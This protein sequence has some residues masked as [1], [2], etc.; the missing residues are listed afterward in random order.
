M[1]RLQV[2]RSFA[3]P[4]KVQSTA[5]RRTAHLENTNTPRA[6]FF[7]VRAA[8]RTICSYFNTSSKPLPVAL[9]CSVVEQ[10]DPAFK[11]SRCDLHQHRDG[12]CGTATSFT[13]ATIDLVIRD[14]LEDPGLW[15]QALHLLRFASLQ[16]MGAFQPRTG[17]QGLE[18]TTRKAAGGT[19]AHFVACDSLS[20]LFY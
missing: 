4:R 15:R 5:P 20:L 13:R 2:C 12:S 3:A 17:A 10:M 19:R 16:G 7:S 1:F 11:S 6:P 14:L 18:I 8:V 9:L